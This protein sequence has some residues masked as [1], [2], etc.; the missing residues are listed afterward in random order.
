MAMG[1]KDGLS[2]TVP[3]CRQEDL[4]AGPPDAAIATAAAAQK[5]QQSERPEPPAVVVGSTQEASRL[6]QAIACAFGEDSSS[7]GKESDQHSVP[8]QQIQEQQKLPASV[9]DKSK[10]LS[11]PSNATK[12]GVQASKK[13][14]TTGAVD[15]RKVHKANVLPSGKRKAAAA[16]QAADNAEGARLTKIPAPV[17]KAAK[18]CEMVSQSA[19]CS[20]GG[21][22]KPALKAASMRGQRETKPPENI[23]LDRV[24]ADAVDWKA[25]ADALGVRIA[26]AE[27]LLADD[28]E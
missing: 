12:K 1:M 7:S 10:A 2:C 13:D 22:G 27:A 6:A 3:V 19:P 8:I 26:E 28:S 9:L 14:G 17:L 16:E 5:N 24:Q 15:S 25:Y 20:K 11:R 4:P 21:S 23:D 18:R